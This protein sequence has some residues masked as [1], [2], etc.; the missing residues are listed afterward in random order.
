MCSYSVF[1]NSYQI[2]KI[3]KYTFLDQEQAPAKLGI[4]TQITEILNQLNQKIAVKNNI[5]PIQKHMPEIMFK[6]WLKLY[7]TINLPSS[8]IKVWFEWQCDL[9]RSNY[10]SFMVK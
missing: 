6:N 3:N 8:N 9:K 2:N 7:K 1:D 5:E 4:T 10:E